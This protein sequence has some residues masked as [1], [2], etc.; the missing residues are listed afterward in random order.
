MPPRRTSQRLHPDEGSTQTFDQNQTHRPST[1]V[2]PTITERAEH[3]TFDTIPQDQL[4]PSNMPT[5]TAGSSQ[6]G[7]AASST[8]TE[9]IKAAV[10]EE[11]LI[12]IQ[13]KIGRLK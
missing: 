1:Q 10:E 7:E 5:T 12:K 4:Q 6:N 9:E 8:Q 2:L 13:Q 3:L 11:E